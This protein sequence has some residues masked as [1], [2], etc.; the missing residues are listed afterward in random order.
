MVNKRHPAASQTFFSRK[1]MAH[2]LIYLFSHVQ[3][4]AFEDNRYIDSS[5]EKVHSLPCG[6]DD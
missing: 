5:S 3:T 1:Q 6:F 2:L 4:G